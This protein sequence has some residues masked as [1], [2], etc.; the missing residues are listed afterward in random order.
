MAAAAPAALIGLQL[1]TS[2][3]QSQ[4]Q[5]AQSEFQNSMMKQNALESERYAQKMLEQGDI[6]AKK[7]K[8]QGNQLIGRQR[9]AF[10][11]SGVDVGYG[12]AKAVQD[13]ARMTIAE[14]VETIKTNAFL[15]AMGYRAQAQDTRRQAEFARR[16]GQF[17]STMTLLT[18]GL[19]AAN[20]IIN[21]G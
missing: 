18:G 4:A 9:A 2:Y 17:N 10:G 21:R 8:Q 6:E 12:T 11:S 20:T 1:W 19:N 3:L 5:L 16:A 14:D 15:Q 7:Y 13:E